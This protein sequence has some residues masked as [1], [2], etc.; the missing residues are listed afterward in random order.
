MM[1]PGGI[2]F[3]TLISSPM[4]F[5]PTATTRPERNSSWQEVPSLQGS[6]ETMLGSGV[7]DNQLSPKMQRFTLTSILSFHFFFWFFSSCV[8][9]SYFS[10]NLSQT[11]IVTEHPSVFKRCRLGSEPSYAV[12]TWEER[13][14]AHLPR[15]KPR[16][17]SKG[18]R[19]QGP[20]ASSYLVL[21]VEGQSPDLAVVRVCVL[22]GDVL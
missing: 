8:R 1:K 3:R 11:E 22:L 2:T 12:L 14:E 9:P 15:H 6:M 4:L 13:R 16:N 17:W 21:V 18:N 19:L 7:N 10:Y 20:L 5:T